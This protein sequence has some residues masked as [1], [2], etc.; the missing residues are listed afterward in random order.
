MYDREYTPEWITSLAE[1]EIFVF[2]CRRSGRHLE[3][4]AAYALEHFGA[5]YGQS[6]GRQGNAYAIATAGVDLTEIRESVDNFLRYAKMNPELHFLVTPIGCGLG[7]WDAEEIAPLF[8]EAVDIK[9]IRLPKEF[10]ECINVNQECGY[11]LE[12]FLMAHKYNYENALREITDGRKRSHWI[13]F[14]F[15]QLAVLGR[16][17]NAK[18]YGIS[19]RDE[20][21]AY[22]DHPILGARLREICMAL[23]QHRG[24]SAVDILGDIDA[25]KVRSCMTLF[26]TVSPDDIFQKVL[27][28]FYD[29][30]RDKKTL[31]YL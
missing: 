11:N 16:S 1:N 5:I 25:V 30:T 17:A 4:A 10:V 7:G 6:N 9:N 24:K 28:A 12:R 29:G 20:A 14:I 13:W 2:G 18:Y 15:P 26:D 27:D 23:L 31:D 21:K 19:G 8:R 3:G 22:L